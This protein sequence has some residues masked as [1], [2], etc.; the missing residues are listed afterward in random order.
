MP[1]NKTNTAIEISIALQTVLSRHQ[2]RK[3]EIGVRSSFQFVRMVHEKVLTAEGALLFSGLSRF[4]QNRSVKSVCI[5][6]L[7]RKANT[8]T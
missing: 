4:S 1:V 3:N 8:T 7:E 6:S 5:S 2:D